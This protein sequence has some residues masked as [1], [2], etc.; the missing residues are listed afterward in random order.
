MLGVRRMSEGPGCS[1]S[2]RCRAMQSPRPSR[3]VGDELIEPSRQHSACPHPPPYLDSGP[4]VPTGAPLKVEASLLRP[5]GALR[6]VVPRGG[7][8]VEAAG[9]QG[10]REGGREGAP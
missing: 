10:G 7:L 8:L 2:P 5:H 1:I 3:R 4:G 9:R 6:S